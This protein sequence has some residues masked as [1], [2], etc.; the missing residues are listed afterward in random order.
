M[1]LDVHGTV[2]LTNWILGFGDKAEVLE[3]LVLRAAVSEELRRA[4]AR[5]AVMGG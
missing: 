3:P 5:Y 1:T 2:E 4:S